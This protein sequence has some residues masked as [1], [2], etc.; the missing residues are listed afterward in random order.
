M[1]SALKFDCFWTAV[2]LRPER[3]EN[4][5]CVGEN[6]TETLFVN[7]HFSDKLTN[8]T[9]RQI[10]KGLLAKLRRPPIGGYKDVT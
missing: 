10:C 3:N 6:N 8:E 9:E 2:V 4:F 5:G 1:V 7:F